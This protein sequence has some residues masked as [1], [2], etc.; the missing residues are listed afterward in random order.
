MDE[1]LATTE[2]GQPQRCQVCEF[3]KIA[4]HVEGEIAGERYSL[5]L[6]PSCFDYTI[7]TLRAQYKQCRLFDDNFDFK[8][9]DDFGK[10]NSNGS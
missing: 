1:P 3:P 9:L 10:L 7:M 5:R 4:G 8:E 2:E 6:C